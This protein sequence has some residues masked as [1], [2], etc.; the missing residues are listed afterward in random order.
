V[1][2]GASLLDD[3]AAIKR[4]DPHD[5]RHVLAD[6]PRQCRAAAGLRAEPRPTFVEPSL[7]VVAGMGGSA[8]GGDI[9]AACAGERL[10][11]P[12]VVHRGYGLPPTASGRAFVVASSYS[13]LTGEV[14][15]AVDAAFERGLAMAVITS[16]GTLRE[17]ATRYGVPTVLLPGGL[18]PRMALGYLL[19]PAIAVLRTIG[20]EVAAEPEI[21]EALDVVEALTTGLVPERPSAENEAKRLALAIGE[22]LPAVYGGPVT[23]AIAYRWK[24]DIEENAKAFALSGVVPEMNH[25][26][27]EAWR[28]P[29]AREMQL[30]LL[31]DHDESPAIARRFAILRELVG[32]AA[33]GVSECWARGR[34]RLA[35]LASLAYLGQWASYYLAILRGVDPWTVPLLDELKRR[36]DVEGASDGVL[37]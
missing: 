24:T 16:G 36:V 33:G 1:S 2:K 7:V 35:R 6:F 29:R 26:A 13:G 31:R 8:A 17:R 27:I 18:M 15:S 19:F 22:R 12:I 10:P 30:V 9:L 11:V 23:G 4:G 3:L 20:L 32:A 21:A 14:L 25:N 37:D 5:T 28:A 34:G